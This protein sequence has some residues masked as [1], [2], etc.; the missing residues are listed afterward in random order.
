MTTKRDIAEDVARYVLA[1][2]KDHRYLEMTVR[3][4][5]LVEL[6]E[7]LDENGIDTFADEIVG[8][9]CN[10]DPRV[11]EDRNASDL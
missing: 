9:V 6:L 1:M 2:V 5:T 7:M 3:L 4:E 10:Y 8:T 11:M